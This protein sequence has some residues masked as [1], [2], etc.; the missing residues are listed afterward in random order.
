MFLFNDRMNIHCNSNPGA[1]LGIGMN[2]TRRKREM[3]GLKSLVE[4]LKTKLGKEILPP[5]RKGS[6]PG[7]DILVTSGSQSM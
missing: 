3:R 6:V 5:P 7:C 4:I 2:K 1:D